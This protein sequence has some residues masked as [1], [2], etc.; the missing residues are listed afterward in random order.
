MK[1]AIAKMFRDI[2]WFFYERFRK[3]PSPRKSKITRSIKKDMYIFS[4]TVMS[5]QVLLFFVFYVYQNFSSILLAF[6]DVKTGSFTLDNFKYVIESVFSS[7][8]ENNTILIALKNTTFFFILT[9]ILMV[10]NV[11]ISCALYKKIWGYKAFQIIFFFPTLIG[12]MVWAT[13]YKNFIA[14]EG[15]LFS[16]LYQAGLVTEIP[17]LLA[18]SRYALGAVAG[19]SVWLGLP[20][21]MLLYCGNLARIPKEILEAGELEG[22]TFLQEVIYLMVPLIWPLIS[23]NLLLTFIGFFNSSGNV[24]LLT[25]G[26]YNTT[27]ISYWMYDQVV[28]GDKY[29]TPAAMGLIMTVLTIPFALVGKWITDRIETVEF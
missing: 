3:I 24:L 15:P 19:M 16:L 29:N 23:T 13:C 27:T 7:S 22:I 18:D 9:L 5:V 17:E 10:P 6:Q 20:S 1:E 26:K 11:L 2:K 8:S 21:G 25:G 12:G 4:W 14:P 28:V